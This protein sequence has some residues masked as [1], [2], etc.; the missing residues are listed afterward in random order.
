MAS[1]CCELCQS[2]A[3]A[4]WHCAQVSLP[5]NASGAA[6]LSKKRAHGVLRSASNCQAAPPARTATAAAATPTTIL[7][8]AGI[9]A[10]ARDARK[11]LHNSKSR[12]QIPK[13]P[14]RS[15]QKSAMGHTHLAAEDPVD[16]DRVNGDDRQDKNATVE[17]ESQ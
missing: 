12:L 16:A 2:F 14:S 15:S 10:S 4:G 3:S 13:A 11:P 1:L 8:R 9:T 17:Q 7:A 6:A 5:T